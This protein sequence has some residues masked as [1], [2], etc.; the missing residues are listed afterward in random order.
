[1]TGRARERT[2]LPA[3]ATVGSGERSR[4][5][6]PRSSC[7]RAVAVLAVVFNH[8]ASR[9]AAG[10]LHRRRHLLRHLRLPDQR[11][12]SLRELRPHRPHPARRVLGPAGPPPAAG[13]RCWSLVST[14]RRR[15][16]WSA[17]DC[18][19]PDRAATAL[20]VRVL[21][22]ELACSAA[23][24]TDY[25][26]AGGSP[27]PVHALLVPRPRG[28]VLPGLAARS[29][30]RRTLSARRWAG[31]GR[32]SLVAFGAIVAASLVYSV[33]ETARV[34]N[35]AYFVT[36]GPRCGSWVSV[37]C[38]AIG[39]GALVSRRHA[40]AAL[41][42]VALLG[43]IW[44]LD[45]GSAV[46]GWIA[47]V[48]VLGTAAVIV[49]RQRGRRAVP[50]ACS[51]PL[52]TGV[53]VGG[54]SY[55]LYLWHWPAIVLVPYATGEPLTVT[56][57]LL[58]LAGMLVLSWLSLRLVE[59]PARQVSWLTRGPARRTF[60]PAVVGMLVVVVLGNLALGTVD[61]RWRRWPTR[62]RRRWRPLTRASLLVRSRTA[63]TTP[64]GCSTPTPRCSA[65]TTI[66]SIPAG[67]R[68]ASRTRSQRQW[69]PAS[70]VSR[71]RPHR[72]GWH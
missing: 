12:R 59:N 3:T 34:P 21:R 46:P 24:R 28:A 57:K 43:S 54:I 31:P 19:W 62:W 32:R 70:S 45:E 56:T 18:Q 30:S 69:S 36:P 2:S 71:R 9:A 4:A 37:A 25:F 1:M 55:S 15:R 64:T 48:P 63:A 40:V 41:G 53:W 52:V 49:G 27:S 65:W 14:V 47:L 44:F 7:L 66:A 5:C 23:I 6:A 33:V 35:A 11:A 39:S 22:P 67:V 20:A 8:L 13:R 26:V 10:R 29:R 42:W 60:V 50:R 16:S 72:S 38:C 68:P 58:L 51:S 17:A 61:R